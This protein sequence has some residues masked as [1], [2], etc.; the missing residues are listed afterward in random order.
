MRKRLE[1]AGYRFG[2]LTALEFLERRN[3]QSYWLLQCDCGNAV[4]ASLGNLRSGQILSCGCS[5]SDTRRVQLTTHGCTGTR[6]YRIWCGMRRRCELVTCSSYHMYGQ[7]GIAVCE[8]WQE[9]A[10]F[11]EWA[12]A[13]GYRDDLSI[14]RSDNNGPYAPWNCTWASA[15]QQARNRRSSRMI[16]IN[17]ELKP[18]CEW[19]EITGVGKNQLLKA[20]NSNPEGVANL[21]RELSKAS[22]RT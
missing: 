20:I 18:L 7:R 10:A 4:Q 17:G 1:L 15:K 5:R 8:E 14:E 13:S 22:S 6:I 19:V 16:N 9:F 11:N 12:I 21:V 3:K 2:K